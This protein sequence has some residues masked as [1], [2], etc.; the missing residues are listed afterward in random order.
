MYKFTSN[1]LMRWWLSYHSCYFFLFWEVSHVYIIALLVL[2]GSWFFGCI[3]WIVFYD[4]C[5]TRLQIFSMESLSTDSSTH[6]SLPHYKLLFRWNPISY[7]MVHAI[8]LSQEGQKVKRLNISGLPEEYYF[9]MLYTEWNWK[10][11]FKWKLT[12]FLFF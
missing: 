1:T 6:F 3:L 7:N 2:C 12:F 10:F 11:F 9:K 8:S 5:N 4:C